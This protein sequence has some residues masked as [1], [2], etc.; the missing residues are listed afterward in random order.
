M[1]APSDSPFPAEGETQVFDYWC[2]DNGLT[3]VYNSHIEGD[4]KVV[5]SIEGWLIGLSDEFAAPWQLAHFAVPIAN[6]LDL[7]ALLDED[8][9]SY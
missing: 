9:S 3:C 4:R 2:L 8:R 6:E 1:I 5:D 7:Q